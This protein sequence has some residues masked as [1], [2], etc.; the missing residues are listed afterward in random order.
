[1]KRKVV[2]IMLALQLALAGT[3]GCSNNNTQEDVSLTTEAS[4]EQSQVSGFDFNRAINNVVIDGEKINLPTTLNEL[5][6]EYTVNDVLDM[7][8]GYDTAHLLKN[9]EEIAIITQV[10]DDNLDIRGKKFVDLC[11]LGKAWNMDLCLLMELV[12]EITLKT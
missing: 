3:V 9:G 5:G 2:L 1:M 6:E 7:E 10:Q 12:E 11:L 4:S 8:D